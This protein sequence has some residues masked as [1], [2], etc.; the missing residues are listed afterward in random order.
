MIPRL[1]AFARVCL[2]IVRGQTYAG[3]GD[4]AQRAKSS[5]A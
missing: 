1:P 5:H 2:R 4:D 3:I